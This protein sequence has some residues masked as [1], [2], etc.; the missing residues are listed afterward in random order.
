MN[1]IT[2]TY[3][4]GLHPLGSAATFIWSGNEASL[5][6][7]HILV[8]HPLSKLRIS[9][10]IGSADRFISFPGGAQLQCGDAPLLDAL[11]QEGATE[12]IVAWLEQRWGMA[13]FGIVVIIALGA[14]GYFYGLPRLAEYAAA[15]VPISAEREVGDTS[16]RW[17]DEHG[18]F[19]PT[20]VGCE[21]QEELRAD[22]SELVR[23]LPHDHDYRLLF[24]NAPGLGAN[25]IAL[26]GGIVVITD[27][28]V[29]LTA[30]PDEALAVLAH[31]V[32][33][34][35]RRHAVRHALQDS[36][37]GAAVT[38]L[39]GDA[40]SLTSVVTGLPVALAQANYSRD[41]ETE[42]DTYA[43]DLLKR[44]DISPAKFA[45][46]MEKLEKDQHDKRGTFSFLASHPPT[47]ERIMRARAAATG[48]DF[49][50]LRT[51][52]PVLWPQWS[53]QP[54]C[55]TSVAQ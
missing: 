29:K 31:E 10:R 38:A 47:P 44:H 21:S 12:G 32:G 33:H 42:A 8:K 17:L 55:Q 5:I 45:E 24:R 15:R 26:P 30:S 39:T 25:A 36:A 46:V 11:P 43:I 18:F 35:E 3:F 20:N 4:D 54:T 49:G 16:L 52:S 37:V 40:A 53:S 28:M 9:P 51:P 2:G 14:Y 41:F 1:K 19:M 34:V 27:G 7:D 23:G 13:L 22:F 6:G 50:A 48:I